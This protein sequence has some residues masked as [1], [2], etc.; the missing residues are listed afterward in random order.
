MSRHVP[1]YLR[2]Q[3]RSDRERIISQG[4]AAMVLRT[5]AIL[6]VLGSIG[7][8][9]AA[10]VDLSRNPHM[11][12]AALLAGPVLNVCVCAASIVVGLRLLRLK[13]WA[14]I[15][16]V[17]GVWLLS[18]GEPWRPV[19]YS[20]G[21]VDPSAALGTSALLIVALAV[22]LTGAWWTER[23]KLTAGF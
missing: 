13:R 15:A 18:L 22:P 2:H 11:G 4:V 21:I 12:A 14:C 20:G 17:A 6:I 23:P 16:A 1:T 3:K 7:T 9:A 5:G 19:H 10:V 8:I